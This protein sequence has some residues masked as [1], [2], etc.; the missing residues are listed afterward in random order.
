MQNTPPRDPWEKFV[1]KGW[2]RGAIELWREGYTAKEIGKKVN[3]STRRVTNRITELRNKYGKD[4]VPYDEDRKKA[5]R[6][7]SRDM[8]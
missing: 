2:D 7:K 6:E 4:L 1:D 3:V 8:K 5:L